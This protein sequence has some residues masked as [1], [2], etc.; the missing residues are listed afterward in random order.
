MSK[1]AFQNA[2]IYL[3][4]I[5]NTCYLARTK[6]L[7]SSK[8]GA[9]LTRIL[10]SPPLLGLLSLILWHQDRIEIQCVKLYT[11]DCIEVNN[12]LVFFALS[13]LFLKT[14]LEMCIC[15]FVT[16][17]LQTTLWPFPSSLHLL[18]ADKT[19]GKKVT[20]LYFLGFVTI[21]C[22]QAH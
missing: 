13:S 10:A 12:F 2:S 11:S 18:L 14:N 9:F 5:Q 21:P 20:L 1:S 17:W 7:C 3:G 22:T 15:F 16:E 4:L 19:G 6:C 8:K